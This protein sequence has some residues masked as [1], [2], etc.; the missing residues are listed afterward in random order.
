[1]EANAGQP[2]SGR[3]GAHADFVNGWDQEALSKLVATLN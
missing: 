2:A 1:M 3:L